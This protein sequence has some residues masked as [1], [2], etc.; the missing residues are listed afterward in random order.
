ML[1]KVF[2]TQERGMCEGLPY[3]MGI[4]TCKLI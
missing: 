4:D 3:E 1:L 2:I